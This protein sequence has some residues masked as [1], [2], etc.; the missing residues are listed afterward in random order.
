MENGSLAREF[1]N[2][3]KRYHSV[4]LPKKVERRQPRF[5]NYPRTSPQIEMSASKI[6]Y[7]IDINLVEILKRKIY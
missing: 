4:A 5:T 3:R 2:R 1:D 7:R 6:I